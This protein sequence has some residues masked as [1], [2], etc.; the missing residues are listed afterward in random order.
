MIEAVTDIVFAPVIPWPALAALA[1]VGLVL[2]LWGLVRRA[3]GTLVRAIPVAALLAAVANPQVVQEDRRPLPD[4]AV[5]VVDESLSQRVGDRESQTALAVQQL[6][7]RLQ[8]DESLEVR[9]ERVGSTLESGTRLFEALS[10]A[11]ADVPR[12]RVAGAVVVTDGQVHDVPGDVADSPPGFP[13][14]TLLTGEPGQTD[15]RLVVERAPDFGLVGKPVE[16]TVRVV[17]EN[18]PPG[19]VAPVTIAV[20]DRP[21]RAVS[22]PI[23]QPVRLPVLIDHAGQTVVALETPG[24]EEDL[25]P[26]N[27]QAA[28]A[29]N[30]VR[31]RLRVLLISGEPHIGE[32]AWRNLLKS[33]PNVDLV[34]FTI[35]RPPSKDDLTPLRELALIAFPIQELFEQRLYDFDLIVF[36]RYTRSGLVPDPY[37]ANVRDY[38]R[39]GGA[40]LLAVGPEFAEPFSLYDSPLGDILPAA[41]SGEVLDETFRPR[42]AGLGL[43]HPVTDALVP[44]PTAQPLGPWVRQIAA[45]PKGDAA[46]VMTG[47]AGEPLLLLDR[48]DDGRVA[49]LLSDTLWLWEKGWRGGG[50]QA[51]LVRR[52][53]HWLM[54]E[55][56]LEERSLRAE[57]SG[58]TL[59]VTRRSLEQG[60]PEV[61]VTSPSGVETTVALEAAEGGMSRATLPVEEPGVW[62]VTDGDMTAIAAAGSANPLE[63]SAVVATDAVMQPVAEAS[64]GGLWWLAEG[65]V[66]D[67]R[68]VSAEAATAGSGWLGLR[69]NGDYVVAGVRQTPLLP[70]WAAILLIL[71]GVV[72]AWWR[73]GR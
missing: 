68:R 17:D 54:K 4:V 60:P 24:G 39:Q 11:T 59:T 1:A 51:E 36:D 56:D 35:L 57:V 6:T 23:G 3:R 33:D 69:A 28:I 8:G 63:T 30:G 44:G 47:A 31:D 7:E 70:L 21:A 48:V 42:V 16:V 20:D 71:G 15:R 55:P 45:R 18:A 72:L 37:M 40:L 19:S 14:H 9:V 58:G 22:V 66:P 64:G 67:V 29:I 46:T 62:R 32:R 2:F 52:L 13:V 12:R 41:P 34:H 49:L 65:G 27:N 43:R 10:R 5:V 25:S 61:T 38:V 26:L 73:E 53:A 50:P